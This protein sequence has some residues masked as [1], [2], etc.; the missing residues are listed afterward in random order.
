MIF[1]T[2][3]HLHIFPSDELRYRLDIA[4]AFEQSHAGKF[5]R[6]GPSKQMKYGY[7]AIQTMQYSIF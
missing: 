4:N 5:L 3:V 1:K 2:E 6:I 7:K